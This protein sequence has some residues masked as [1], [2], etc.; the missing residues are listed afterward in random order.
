VHNNKSNVYVRWCDA[1]ISAVPQS[2]INFVTRTVIGE[3]WGQLLHVAK[4]VELGQRLNHQT[5][6]QN[7][8]ELYEYIQQR[9]EAMLDQLLSAHETNEHIRFVSYLQS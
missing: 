6:I 8:P 3:I 5:A 7:Q 4:Q 1:K 2:I 9:V